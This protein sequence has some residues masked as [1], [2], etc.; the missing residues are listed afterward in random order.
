MRK[1][2]TNQKRT[3]LKCLYP[4]AC[5]LGSEQEELELH[6]WT[7]SCEIIGTTEK[8]WGSSYGWRSVIGR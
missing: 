8:W 6:V 5:N 7:Q 3:H 4:N 1:D 2:K